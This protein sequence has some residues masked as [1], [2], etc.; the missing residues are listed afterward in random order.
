MLVHH[1]RSTLRNKAKQRLISAF[2]PINNDYYYLWLQIF[3]RKGCAKHTF[4]G[5]PSS[6]VYL[7][8]LVEKA[9]TNNVENF[10]FTAVVDCLASVC[11]GKFIPKQTPSCVVST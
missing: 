9:S 5:C 6:S 10:S 4:P 8:G 11:L 1:R 7:F 3:T 2:H